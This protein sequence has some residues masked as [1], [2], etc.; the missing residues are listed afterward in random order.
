MKKKVDLEYYVFNLTYDYKL[1]RANILKSDELKE[2]IY[3]GVNSGKIKTFEE[4]RKELRYYFTKYWS[5]IEFEY[6]ISGVFQNMSSVMKKDNR[7]F[8]VGK[9]I[10]VFYQI[11]KNL[12]MITEYIIHKMELPIEIPKKY[13]EDLDF[14]EKG[15]VAD[16]NLIF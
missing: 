11:E 5:R 2:R 12:N 9:K 14:W 7:D 6:M 16:E 10:D 1:Y 8:P 15:D 3:N 13:P 4:L